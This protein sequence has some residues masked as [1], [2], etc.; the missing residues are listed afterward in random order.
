VS[1][2]EIVTAR[3]RLVA[4]T[5]ELLSALLDGTASRLGY[6]LPE[7]W[8]PESDAR[9]FA[10]KRDQVGADASQGQWLRFLVLREQGPGR[11][12]V[13]GAG[14]GAAAG[15]AAGGGGGTVV[16]HAGFHGP[17]GVNGAATPGALEIGYTVFAAWR[18]AGL[19]TEAAGALLRWARAAHDVTHYYG[20]TSPENA[21]SRAVLARLGFE[22][23]GERIDE[24]DGLELVYEL[25]YL[26]ALLDTKSATA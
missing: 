8:L 11:V 9:F 1:A 2:P 7:R 25:R 22:H 15:A 3:L 6:E 5:A 12:A 21:A 20:S 24:E 18:G 4:G 19:A 17:P 14:L 13:A 26:P 23:V 16:G 10:L